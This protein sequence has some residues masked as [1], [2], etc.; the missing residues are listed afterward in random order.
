MASNTSISPWLSVRDGKRALEFYKNAFG[1][2]IAWQLDTPDDS[3]VAKLAISGAEFWISDGNDT[4]PLGGN[5]I[6]LI[7]TVDDP[8]TLF[9]RAIKAGAN[10]VHPVGDSHGW[11]IGRLIDPFGLHWE[12]G[13]EL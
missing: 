1:A 7:L 12:I 6:R 10:E 2:T 3:V 5:S 11:R 9:S 8:D 13:R 4:E